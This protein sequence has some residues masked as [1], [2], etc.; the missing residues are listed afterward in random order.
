MTDVG[1]VVEL[2]TILLRCEIFTDLMNLKSS[3][4]VLVMV[5]L[6]SSPLG[7]GV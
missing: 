6:S 7:L 3:F 4:Y 1:E 2:F 5:V